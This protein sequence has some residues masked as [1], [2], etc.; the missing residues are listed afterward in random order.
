MIAVFAIGAALVGALLVGPFVSYAVQRWVGWRV[1]LPL[2]L[3]WVPTRT[4]IGQPVARCFRCDATLAVS[5]LPVR[6]WLLVG[7]RC[8]ACHAA[9]GRWPLAIE[10]TTGALFGLVAWRLDGPSRAVWPALA[11]VTGLVAISTVDLAFSR[12]PTRFVYLTALAVA[13][14][15]LPLAVDEPDALVG[16]AVGGGACLVLLGGMHLLSPRMLGF[17]DVR[18]G[19]LV[20]AVVGWLGWTSVEP[21][22]D[23]L[24]QVV[25]AL[26]LAGVLG[27]LAGVVVLAVRRHNV[28][29]PFGPCLALGAIVALVL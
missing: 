18:L 21:V 23:P 12:I 13:I 11:L 6:P 24:G 9:V 14:T 17:G 27:S 10:L 20:G 7:G 25:T 2:V 4:Q 16:V 22:L 5:S 15:G 26:F 19:T 3:D 28:P 8:R 29:Y 1:V